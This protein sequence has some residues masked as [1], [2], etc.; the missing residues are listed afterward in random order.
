MAQLIRDQLPITRLD[1]GVF[2]F[3]DRVCCVGDD[4]ACLI[5]LS[6]DASDPSAAIGRVR[7]PSA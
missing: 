1:S 5:L 6:T 4:Q 3:G 7:R 2:T